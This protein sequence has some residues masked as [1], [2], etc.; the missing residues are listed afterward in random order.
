MKT[1]LFWD[2]DGTLLTTGRAGMF[3]WEEAAS[4][5]V[6]RS[7]DLQRLSTAGLTDF[8]VGRSILE[9]LK[10]PLDRDV[11]V[12]MVRSYETRLPAALPRR[13]GRVFQGVAEV[14]RYARDERTD[15]TSHLLTGNTAAG[16][17]AKLSYYGIWDL[18]SGGAFAE[19]PDTR[20]DIARRAL[21][22][23]TNRQSI[24]LD[25]VFVIGDTPHDVACGKAIGAKTIAVATGSFTASELREY[26]PWQTWETVPDP[27]SFF[28][29]L[30][31]G[32]NR[33]S[34][35]SR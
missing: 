7:I 12:R 23:I 17:R 18:F 19:E 6:G 3:A 29:M 20:V 2:I 1:V 32:E 26:D 34:L 13:K 35:G 16:A 9:L 25:R 15:V 24:S 31:I 27:P 33:L 28:S 8:A 10:L 30:S 21:R 4:E 22:T 11:L 14:L 5:L